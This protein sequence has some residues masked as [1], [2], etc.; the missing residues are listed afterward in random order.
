[1]EKHYI[2]TGGCGG[3]LQEPGVCGT[4]NCPHKGQAMQECNCADG[5]HKQ[6]ARQDPDNSREEDM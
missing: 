6:A 5:F 2:C 3:S 1:M 4:E